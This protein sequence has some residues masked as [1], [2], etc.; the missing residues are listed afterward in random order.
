MPMYKVLRTY[1]CTDVYHITAD[2][3]D[4]A[5]QK[6]VNGEY[7]SHKSYYGDEDTSREV[8]QIEE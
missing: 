8:I 6:A 3:E 5:I 4:E 1:E 7:E 2:S